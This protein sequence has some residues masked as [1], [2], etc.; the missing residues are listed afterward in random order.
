MHS[1]GQ[2]ISDT[3]I[4]RARDRF[5]QFQRGAA[6]RTA[7]TGNTGRIEFKGVEGFD[8]YN[9][10]APFNSG[11]RRVIAGRV[12]KRDSEHSQVR[13]FEP[14]QGA[15]QLI[16]EAPQF[17]LQ[18]PFFTF[19]GAE[20]VFGGVQITE[21]APG[22]VQWCTAF[23]RGRDIFSLQPFFTG[24]GGM[25]DIRLSEL[26]DGRLAVFTRPQGV[27]GGRGTIGCTEADSLDALS[28]EL[29]EAA[30]LLEGMFHPMDW[31][32][33]NETVRLPGGRIGVLAHVACFDDDTANSDRHYY[34]TSF[35]F[36][37]RSRRFSDF[38]I[39]A[40]RAQFGAGAAKRPD[41]LDV[42]F[43][44][45]LV[46]EAGRTL[47]YVGASDAEAHWLEIDDPFA[48]ERQA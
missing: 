6:G 39:I 45:G 9:I 37:P 10:T 35:V 41:L 31:G 46:F 20:L 14:S 19:I 18:D 40:S 23:F 3:P 1:Q 22:R 36:D 26:P 48:A 13:F 34:A 28:I 29:I 12:E 2:A 30:P 27:K 24:P 7:R 44:S 43:S 4:I 17:Q 16:P 11:G 47:L 5:Q 32:G 8:V 42:V 21:L 33:V 38:K 25:K 15:W